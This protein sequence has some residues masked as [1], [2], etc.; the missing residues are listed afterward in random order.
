[1]SLACELGDW[2]SQSIAGIAEKEWTGICESQPRCGVEAKSSTYTLL[3]DNFHD[4][5]Q[6]MPFY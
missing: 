5:L 2:M 4:Y 1:M 3:Y 6:K